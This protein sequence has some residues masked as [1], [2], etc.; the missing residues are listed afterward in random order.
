MQSMIAQ[1]TSITVV[2]SCSAVFGQDDTTRA[3]TMS[4]ELDHRVV[5]V[6]NRISRSTKPF[7]FEKDRFAQVLRSNGF[8][9]ITKGVYLAQDIYVEGFKRDDITIVIDGEHYHS[10]CPNRMDSPLARTN[11]LEMQSITLEKTSSDLQSGLGGSV[12]YQREA[13]AVPTRLRAGFAQAIGAYP[14]WDLAF[15][16]TAQ[17]HRVAGQYATGEGYDDGDGKSFV[18]R[19][20]Y[21]DNVRYLLAD[22]AVSGRQLGWTYRG[23]LTYTEDV[24]FP[25]LMM[26]ERTNRV[27]SSSAG[28]RDHKLY[29]NYT[30]HLM[31]NGLRRSNMSMYTD[32]TNLTVG[33]T[34]PFYDIFYRRWDADNRIITPT[35]TINNHLMPAVQHW[36]AAAIY[37]DLYKNIRY[38]GRFGIGV[39]SH[40][41]A[42]SAFFEPLYGE[43]E[44][45]RVF[46]HG[47]AGG[48]WQFVQ[49]ED[50]QGKLVA[51]V[52][53][54]PP[55]AQSMF[56]TVQRPMGKPWWSGNPDLN[57]PIR[58][59]LRSEI[60]SYGAGVELSASYV[61]DY[62]NL[63]GRSAGATGQNYFTYD[64][65]DALLLS[66]SV[67]G[68]WRYLDT[69]AG[70]TR[71]SVE[72]SGHPLSE[73]PP[74][75][76]SYIVKSPQVYGAVAWLRH[77]Y[78]DAQTRI[79]ES[80]RE[81]PSRAWHRFDLG[82]NYAAGPL[83][84]GLEAVNLFDEL[85]A[86][87]MSYAR[88]PYSAGT[89]VY[90]PGRTLR[91]NVHFDGR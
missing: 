43:V 19:Y 41:E 30:D 67:N 75:Y 37:E 15:S 21:R 47:A 14:A 25:Y 13:L 26:D 7:P 65:V 78:N 17:N 27:F 76:V 64:N 4:V 52:I 24:M 35:T 49:R 80:L 6:G 44:S 72:P 89:S 3:D 5:V 84:F 87:H 1:I 73:V 40:D 91:L 61:W 85:Y 9:L 53:I 16:A 11:P 63:V 12:A 74:L 60:R 90:E 33:A 8:G 81:F 56:I 39:L 58:G 77:E 71:A 23:E 28:Y 32:A 54:D 70:Y 79:D 34:G 69:H 22:I 59:S 50:V 2:L 29:A 66:V 18:H 68:S 10:A 83:V 38:W 48:S 82:V 86:R 55:S 36:N 88:N 31:D 45:K 62:V 42:R 20:G 46:A 51:D 57:A